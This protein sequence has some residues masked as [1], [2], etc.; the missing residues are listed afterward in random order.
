M[1]LYYRYCCTTGIVVLQVLLY[2]RYCYTAGIVVLQVLLHY[3]CCCTGGIVVDIAVGVIAGTTTDI[4]KDL[5]TCIT[6]G[7]AR[8]SA[9]SI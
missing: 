9:S 8:V 2:R 7:V 6:L 3:R 1:L 5:Y 4:T